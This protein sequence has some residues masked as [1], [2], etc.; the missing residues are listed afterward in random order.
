MKYLYIRMNPTKWSRVAYDNFVRSYTSNRYSFVIDWVYDVEYQ[1]IKEVSPFEF[2]RI[3][4]S[5][6]APYNFVSSE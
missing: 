5:E 2:D 3:L 1:E 4:N 6:K